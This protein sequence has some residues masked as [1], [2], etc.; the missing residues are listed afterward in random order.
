MGSKL[1]HESA[2]L[3]WNPGQVTP[4]LR[5]LLPSPRS[6]TSCGF[7]NLPE[8]HEDHKASGLSWN[9]I[10]TSTRHFRPF[11]FSLS[12]LSRYLSP[13][14]GQE[15]LQ[16]RDY[17]LVTKHQTMAAVSP[18]DKTMKNRWTSFQFKVFLLHTFLNRWCLA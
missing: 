14:R 4:I 12:Q 18:W 8:S 9:S 16:R 17:I 11:V 15:T 2:G 10:L 7:P 6:P 13:L 1:D 5:T 3:G